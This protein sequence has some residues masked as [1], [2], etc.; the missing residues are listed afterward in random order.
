MG[1]LVILEAL[2]S[3]PLPPAVVGVTLQDHQVGCCSHAPLC[4]LLDLADLVPGTEYGIGIS[5]VMDSQ[6]SVPATMNARTGK[7]SPIAF[8]L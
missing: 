2:G 8:G 5:A 6:Q 7:S 4:P 3:V 1:G